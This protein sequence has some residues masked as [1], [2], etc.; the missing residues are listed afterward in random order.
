MQK[1][2][3]LAKKAEGKVSPN[4]LVGCVILDSNNN[5]IS[6]GYHQKYGENHAERNALIK[7]NIYRIITKNTHLSIWERDRN[8]I[9]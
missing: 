2:L 1:C 5:I 8:L 3:D 4:P 7:Q 9:N 6:E